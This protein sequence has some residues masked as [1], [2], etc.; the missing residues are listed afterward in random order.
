MIRSFCYSA[1][2]TLL[3]TAIL[4]AESPAPQWKI[5][6]Q[7]HQNIEARINYEV[8][9]TSYIVSRWMAYLPE[10]PELPSQTNIKVTT[11]QKSKLMSERSSIARKVRQFD[12]PVPIPSAA[13]KLEL[14]MTVQATLRTR[15]LVPLAMGETPPKVT[16]LTPTEAKY[17]TS[18]GRDIDF[19]A[20]SFKAWLDKKDLHID[21]GEQ[22]IDFA[23]RILQVIRDDYAYG[24]NLSE[25]KAS[26]C[27]DQ[28]TIDCSGMSFLFVAAMRANAIPARIL[29]G[30]YARP[31][32]MDAKPREQEYDQPHVRAEFYLADVGW[33]AIDASDAN[34][35]KFRKVRD[36][37]GLDPGNMLVLHVD[38]DLKLPY[39][40]Q[41]QTAEGLQVTPAYWAAGRGVFDGK[42]SDSGWDL[43]ATPIK[44]E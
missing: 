17:Y 24:Y 7:D 32:K 3:S 37:I 35:M 39:P 25:K 8:R 12:I 18:P 41:V 43:T 44:K 1:S 38:V 14:E 9:T 19:K 40:D 4:F 33:I 20:K 28:G 13:S 16:P 23:E 21:K 2:I 36:F 22:P 11:K 26:L 42:T 10:P 5:V 29:I 27:C 6:A 31:R 15:R 34:V 30:R